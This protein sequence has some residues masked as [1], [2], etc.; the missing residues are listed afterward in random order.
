MTEP[1][2]PQRSPLRV[3]MHGTTWQV[4]L[5]WAM[6][7]TGVASTVLLARLLTPADYGIVAIATLILGSIEIFSEVGLYNAVV[8]HPNP[9]REHYDSAWTLTLLLGLGLALI[10]LAATPLTVTYF[11]EP[12][13]KP[14]LMVLALRT[15]LGGFQNVAVLNFQRNFQ[16][17]KQFQ[18]NVGATTISFVAVVTSAFMLRNYWA[19]VIGIMSRQLATLALSYILEPYRPRLSLSKAKE[20]FSFSFWMLVTNIGT[21]AINQVDKVAIGGFAGA[22][23]M[24]R[25]DVGRDVASSPI[26]E[27]VYPMAFVLFPVMAKFQN[28]R[29]KRREL[30]L[31]ALAWSAL[32]CTST[33]V[34]VSLVADDMTDLLLGAQ[35][36]SVKPMIPWFALAVGIFGLTMCVY[37]TLEALGFAYQSARLQWIRVAGLALVVFPVAFYFRD[38][39]LVAIVRFFYAVAI[40]P[41]LFYALSRALN[42]PMRD[43]ALVLWRPLVSALAMAVV[44]LAANAG[45]SF[46][47]VWRLVLDVLLGAASFVSA[48]IALWF[49]SGCPSGPENV[50][51]TQLG[52]WR[53]RLTGKFPV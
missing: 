35:W 29:D 26:N 11:N 2:V 7:L 24:G 37:S 42:V 46:T 41:M 18:M 16:F 10:V 13:A 5:R 40:S 39:G 22:A 3:L 47:G 15:A 1:I 4:A 49:A 21:Y 51:W 23:A 53:E 43:F 30:F 33:A 19:L 28:D 38:V 9:T 48:L 50:L 34:G 8:R 25:Y 36:D 27:L 12:R 32:I 6:R 45:I 52:K 14:V 17:H 44:V 31:S 20:L